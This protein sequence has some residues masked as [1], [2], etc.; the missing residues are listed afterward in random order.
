M[1]LAAGDGA[2]KAHPDLE[3]KAEVAHHTRNEV[4]PKK[5]AD[6]PATED[7]PDAA[8]IYAP[9]PGETCVTAEA[10]E[11]EPHGHR[12]VEPAAEDDTYRTLAT[13]WKA[14]GK[15]WSQKSAS[16]P[17]SVSRDQEKSA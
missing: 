14:Q 2:Q 11:E 12:H 4:L 8:E 9:Q 17:L 15:K 13:T 3:A 5:F 6:E 10:G 1:E 7:Q 16:C